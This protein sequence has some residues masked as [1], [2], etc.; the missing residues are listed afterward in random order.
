MTSRL[1]VVDLQLVEAVARHGSVGAAAKELLIAQPSASRR[2]LALERRLSTKLFDRDTTG[3]RATPAGRELA[4]HAARL[5]SDLDALPD[6]VLAAVDTPTL[7]VGTIQALSPMVFTALEI[8][9]DSVSVRPEIDH[10]P[11]LLQ[12]V[13]EGTLDAAII[14][15][16]QQTVVPRGLQRTV[17]GQSP[18]VIMLP[19]G[20]ADLAE[21]SRPFAEQMVL[22]STIDL[23]GEL[24]H[25]R[26]SALGALP[27]PG[28]T[29]EA[30]LRIARHHRCPALVPELVARWYAARGDRLV[31]SPMPGQVTVSLVSRS[32][33]PS[34]LTRALPRITNRILGT[35]WPAKP[36]RGC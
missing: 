29:T 12:Q 20:A 3:A 34:A 27:C 21:G 28:A 4:R 26:L 10:G 13:H 31:P 23:A 1:T 25:E 19:K 35:S 36:R 17:I 18:L 33:Q 15:I 9:L 7:A 32:P 30:T 14:T 16:A 11:V 6:Q 24:L 22:Y 2:L 5:L 8:E